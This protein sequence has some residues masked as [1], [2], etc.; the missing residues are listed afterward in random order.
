MVVRDHNMLVVMTSAIDWHKGP[1]LQGL[2]REDIIPA[3][4]SNVPLP[5]NTALGHPA[6]EGQIPR[7]SRAART[8]FARWWRKRSTPGRR[9][10]PGQSHGLEDHQMVKGGNPEAQVIEA[11]IG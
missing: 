10:F 11:A 9:R 4:A 3:A 2:L 6:G 7:Q 8:A 1:A 5:A